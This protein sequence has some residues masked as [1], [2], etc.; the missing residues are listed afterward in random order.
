MA[1][2]S[3]VTG[4]TFHTHAHLSLMGSSQTQTGHTGINTMGTGAF[5]RIKRSRSWLQLQRW[6]DQN[7]MPMHIY[8]SWIVHRHKLATL[9]SILWTQEGAQDQSYKS[10]DRGHRIKNPHPCTFTPHGWS[11]CAGRVRSREYFGHRGVH[12]KIVDGQTERHT[13]GENDFYRA[14]GF[15]WVVVIKAKQAK[16]RSNDLAV[17]RFGSLCAARM[18][19]T[20]VL[21]LRRYQKHLRH[22]TYMF[23][24]LSHLTKYNVSG[25]NHYSNNST[26]SI[27]RCPTQP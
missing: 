19:N 11:P 23:L 6:E 4:Q 16:S 3:K 24:E 15:S 22:M 27:K 5:R 13:D 2:R 9:V 8:P 1:P 20:M 10:K 14:P 26:D 17:T 18:L 7:F 21:A 25:W 12:K